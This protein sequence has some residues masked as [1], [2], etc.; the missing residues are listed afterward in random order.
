MSEA[1]KSLFIKNV[2]TLTGKRQDKLAFCLNDQKFKN[3]VHFSVPLLTFRANKYCHPVFVIFLIILQIIVECCETDINSDATGEDPRLPVNN[4]RNSSRTFAELTVF[5]FE[6]SSLNKEAKQT[7]KL[8]FVR[9]HR[10]Q[11]RKFLLIVVTE[12]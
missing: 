6:N 10:Q 4:G 2:P 1:N 9:E 7:L 3:S 8:H 12:A 11:S 5:L